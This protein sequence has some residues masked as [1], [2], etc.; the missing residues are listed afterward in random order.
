MQQADFQAAL[1][2]FRRA[3]ELYPRPNIL[4]NVAVCLER[5]GDRVG[6]IEAY[7]RFLAEGSAEISAEQRQ[8]AEDKIRALRE[9]TGS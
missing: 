2:S 5:L 7:E 6:A 9:Q 1:A 8:T 4:F 3:Y